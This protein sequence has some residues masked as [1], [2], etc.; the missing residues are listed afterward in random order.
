MIPEFSL[1]VGIDKKHLEQFSYTF[2][3]WQKNK[4]SILKH[5]IFIFYDQTQILCQD[6]Y[7]ITNGHDVQVIPYPFDDIDY[8]YPY[9]GTRFTESQRC[10]MLSGFA[11]VASEYVETPYWL[12]IDTDVVAAGHDD[13]I[14]PKWFE[15][16]PAIVSHPWSFTKPPNQMMLLDEWAE[17]REGFENTE[18]LNLIPKPEADRVGHKRI[19]SWCGFFQTGFT[20]L[21]TRFA[22]QPDG[23][24]HMPC[25]SQDGYMWWAAARL[26]WPIERPNMK[27]H[28]WQ[29]WNCMSNIEK[30]AKLAL[31]TEVNDVLW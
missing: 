6:I 15:Q 17:G 9:D 22:R 8:F 29:Q 12:K 1:V 27:K 14:D 18:P 3:T 23:K 26:G 5:P 11:Y 2:P 10:K 16:N 31:R 20:R 13:W 25:P 28:G 24:F 4:P 30:H 21:C 7:Q 19:I